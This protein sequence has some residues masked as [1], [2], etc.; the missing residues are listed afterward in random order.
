M[1]KKLPIPKTGCLPSA[2][3]FA[4]CNTS[5][6]R[7]TNSLPSVGPKT[8]GKNKTLGKKALC[9]VSK[10][11]HSAK[12]FFAE[13]QKN[14]LGKLLFFFSFEPQTFSDLHIQHVVLYA[15]VWCIF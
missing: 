14:T 3:I 9:R 2:R 6:T 7:Q 4:E 8:I 5:G 12:R 13:C 1:Q 10:K 15:Q 11:L